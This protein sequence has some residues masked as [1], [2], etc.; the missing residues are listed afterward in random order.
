LISTSGWDLLS[1]NYLNVNLKALQSNPKQAQAPLILSDS[2]I[3]PKGYILLTHEIVDPPFG[4]Q[5]T[6]P[7]NYYL[8][9]PKEMGAP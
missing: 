9:S 6:A 3:A 5:A 1:A 2:S 7:G 8:F 4:Y